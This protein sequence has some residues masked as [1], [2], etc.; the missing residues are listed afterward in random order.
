MPLH[1]DVRGVRSGATQQQRGLMKVGRLAIALLM[2]WAFSA[3]SAYATSIVAN[4]DF[5]LPVVPAGAPGY[6]FRFT[7]DPTWEWTSGGGSAFR[8]TVQ[9]NADYGQSVGAGTQSVQLEHP[10]DFISQVLTTIPGAVYNLSFLLASYVQP[11][12]SSLFVTIDGGAPIPFL[13]TAAWTLQT[14]S[15]TADFASTTLRFESSG[16]SVT[17]PHLDSISVE[18]VPE[19]ATLLLFGTG[20]A[21]AGVR[22]Y[23]QRK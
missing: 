1:T 15:F 17:Y 12:T 6:Q 23:R 9:F 5:E 4:G 14:Y 8:G 22:R 20:L 3:P 7:G 21:A 19:P 18:A 11:G 2:C 10:G 13:G 16:S